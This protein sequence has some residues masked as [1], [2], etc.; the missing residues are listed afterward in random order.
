MQLEETGISRSCRS[1]V[2]PFTHFAVTTQIGVISRRNQ[3]MRGRVETHPCGRHKG[4]L[5]MQQGILGLLACSRVYGVFL[6]AVGHVGSFW[7]Q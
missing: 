7:V 5:W 4:S 3:T 2:L 6:D 1:E